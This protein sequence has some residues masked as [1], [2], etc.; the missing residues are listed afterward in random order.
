MKTFD[1]RQLPPTETIGENFLRFAL[2]VALR[3]QAKGFMWEGIYPPGMED[4][5][6]GG[7][8]GDDEPFIPEHESLGIREWIIPGPIDDS[9]EPYRAFPEDIVDHNCGLRY[10]NRTISVLEGSLLDGD[11]KKG[12]E[13]RVLIGDCEI[14]VAVLT[15]TLDGKARLVFSFGDY[16]PNAL[17]ELFSC[18]PQFQ[19]RTMAF[20]DKDGL[21]Y[22][23]YPRAKTGFSARAILSAM[24]RLLSKFW[25]A[26]YV[27][28]KKGGQQ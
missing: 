24:G 6:F 20:F 21:T 11:P 16:D 1:L 28:G 14:E 18:S 9:S 4:Y 17:P 8:S 5:P 25:T 23:T 27:A 13:F 19:N 3:L 26:N 15:D 22:V 12:S 2:L 7:E 10:L